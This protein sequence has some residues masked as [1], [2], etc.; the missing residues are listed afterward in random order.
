MG[1]T[2]FS[3]FC[4][5]QQA[6]SSGVT[7]R[8]RQR[9]APV[10]I[11]YRRHRSRA[12][13]GQTNARLVVLGAKMWYPGACCFALAPTFSPPYPP[14][15]LQRKPTVEQSRPMHTRC[16]VLSRWKFLHGGRFASTARILSWLSQR[17]GSFQIRTRHTTRTLRREEKQKIKT[18]ESKFSRSV[19]SMCRTSLAERVRGL[20]MV[21]IT[22]FR[23][24]DTSSGYTLKL[25]CNHRAW[26]R[27]HRLRQSLAR[28]IIVRCAPRIT[29]VEV[30]YSEYCSFNPLR[31]ILTFFMYLR[32]V[33]ILLVHTEK[34]SDLALC[35]VMKP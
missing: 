6:T 12:S 4:V 35:E 2:S 27:A 8:P 16:S 7:P 24:S 30:T 5:Q 29:A 26:E 9:C 13:S 17:S 3:K 25:L 19:S 21:R 32:K 11:I 10:A 1:F 18:K 34:V 14:P 33:E 23:Y 15:T 22:T 31:Y 28:N 20:P